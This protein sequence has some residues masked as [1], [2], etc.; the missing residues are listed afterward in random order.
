[1]KKIGIIT[2]NFNHAEGLKATLQSV[3]EQTFRDYE[4]VVVDGGSSD[5]SVEWLKEAEHVTRWISE[6]DRGIYDAQNKGIGM[7]TAEYLLFLNSGDT[8]A[9]PDVLQ[10]VLPLLDG[11]ADIVYGN[12]LIEENGKLREGVMPAQ[13]DLR[14]MMRDTLWHPVSFIHHRLFEKYGGYNT[15]YQIV[16]DY[17]FFF[18]MIVK[19]KVTAVHIPL[20][21]SVF[22]HDGL[23]ADPANVAR[24]RAEKDRVQRS[25]LSEAEIKAF[26]DEEA[27]RYQEDQKN[28]RWFRRW[29]RL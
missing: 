21:I 27:R 22:R 17:D 1:M 19:E 15:Q 5:Q 14:Q 16:A 2:I 11:H 20:F 6:N 25:V 28:S 29:F 24:I 8:L 10:K 13:I 3:R 7:G 4:Y 26:H 23:S 18:R 9:A 12:M